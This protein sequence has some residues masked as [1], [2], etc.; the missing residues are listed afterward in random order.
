MAEMRHYQ[1]YYGVQ[2]SDATFTWGGR[3]YDYLLVKKYMDDEVVS[4]ATTINTGT[5][6]FLYPFRIQ[7]RFFIEGVIEG[8]IHVY[9]HS[10]AKVDTTHI[11]NN[12]TVKLRKIDNSD[13]SITLQ[14]KVKTINRSVATLDYVCVPF[15]MDVVS[16]QEFEENERFA[17]AVSISSP[18]DSLSIS[19]E[20]DSSNDDFRIN[21]G[22]VL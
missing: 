10:Q 1:T 19:H 5:Y 21:I 18:T 16:K 8:H 14:E 9:N 3:E 15:F 13:A 12:Y 7:Q 11:I 4:S 22:M 20:N 2:V 6:T 17:I